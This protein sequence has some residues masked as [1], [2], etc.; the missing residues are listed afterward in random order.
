[1]V[2]NKVYYDPEYAPCRACLY[3][4]YRRDY[5]AERCAVCI[6]AI[7]KEVKRDCLKCGTGFILKDIPRHELDRPEN[8]LCPE[9]RKSY[10]EWREAH[11]IQSN[12]IGELQRRN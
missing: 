8:R 9:C 5:L 11:D 1:M 7:E 12:C 2:N 10:L 6:W 4:G 3:V